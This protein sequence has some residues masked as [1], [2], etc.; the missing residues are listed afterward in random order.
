MGLLLNSNIEDKVK[1]YITGKVG[2]IGG[3]M[4][5]LMNYKSCKVT[6]INIIDGGY[7]K[8][9]TKSSLKT[10]VNFYNTKKRH[11]RQEL[12]W[13][14]YGEREMRD[15]KTLILDMHFAM[16]NPSLEKKFDATVSSN[17]I[18]HSPN[19]IWLL[20]NFHFITKDNGYQ[21]H[22]IPNYRYTFDMYRKP[23]DL[24]IVIYYF[25]KMMWFI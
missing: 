25:K 23:T 8:V 6:D 10:I 14:L 22:A 18:E 16:L 3:R 5:Q 12:Y 7:G 17:M 4:N 2:R 19:P 1:H 15:R 24:K 13:I 11:L 9:R 21:Y 20:L